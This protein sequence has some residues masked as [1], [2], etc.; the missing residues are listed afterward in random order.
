MKEIARWIEDSGYSSFLGAE[1]V[2]IDSEN[3]RLRLPWNPGNSNPGEVLHG[4]CAASLGILGGQAV[5]RAAL[6]PEAGG[7]HTAQL[8]VAYLAAA[9]NEEVTAEARLLRR[10]KTLCFVRI[11]VATLGGKPIASIL[12]TVRGRCGETPA[13]TPAHGGDHRES[14][15]SEIGGFIEQQ[16]FIANRKLRIEHMTGGTSR[17]SMPFSDEHNGDAEGGVHEGAVAAL[18]D[19]CGAMAAWAESGIGPYR[20]STVS[21]QSES[22]A[23]APAEDLVAYGRCTHRD[24]DMFWADVDITVASTSNLIGRGTVLY[25]IVTA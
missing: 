25:R 14:D 16:P 5:A 21:L 24:G 1:L 4:G 3:A 6:G 8:Q 9:Q 13:R 15:P 23:P 22:L 12:T 2:E 19:T 20:A 7:F 10:G 11:D 17:L 18:L